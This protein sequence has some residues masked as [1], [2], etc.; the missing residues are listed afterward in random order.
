VVDDIGRATADRLVK[1]NHSVG[2]C[3]RD[4]LVFPGATHQVV[5]FVI[6]GRE[7]VVT[8]LWQALNFCSVTP[9]YGLLFVRTMRRIWALLYRKGPHAVP[10][11][12]DFLRRE[13]LTPP[14]ETQ[15][16]SP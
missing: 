3:S 16:P 14:C 8:C 12:F 4:T 13:M 5:I 6:E 11:H 15:R 10:W 1:F 9:F 7:Y 2:D